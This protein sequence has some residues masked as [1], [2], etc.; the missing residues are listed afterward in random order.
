[1]LAA[2]CVNVCVNASIYANKNM[3][4]YERGVDRLQRKAVE[5]K[6]LLGLLQVRSMRADMEKRSEEARRERQQRLEAETKPG[7]VD[8]IDLE[9]R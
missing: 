3:L 4:M 7:T 8:I 5:T 9:R 6:Y 2:V 1:M